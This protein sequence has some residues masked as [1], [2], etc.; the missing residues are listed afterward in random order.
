MST[1]EIEAEI[2]ATREEL[3]NTVDELAARLGGQA[4]RG[5]TVLGAAAAIAAVAVVAVALWRRRDR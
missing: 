5:A 2:Q 4:R 1:H 3:A